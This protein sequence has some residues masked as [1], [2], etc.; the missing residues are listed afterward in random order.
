MK[1]LVLLSVI[2]VFFFEKNL[3]AQDERIMRKMLSGSLLKEEA[4]Q[5]STLHYSIDSSRYYFDLDGDKIQEYFQTS[6]RDGQLWVE[7]RQSNEGLLYEVK[8]DTLNIDARVYK[9]KISQINPKVKLIMLFTYLGKIEV[10]S[11]FYSEARLFFIT[12]E[13]SQ[14]YFAHGPYYFMEKQKLKDQ[15]ANRHSKINLFDYNLDNT[16]DVGVEYNNIQEIH[17]YQGKGKWLKI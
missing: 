5:N 7:I 16:I 3:L 8:L 12:L 1:I 15:Y 4:E 17:S 9:I 13:E 6:H 11:L 14:F 10:P 2:N